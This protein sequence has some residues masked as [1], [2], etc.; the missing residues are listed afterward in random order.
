MHWNGFRSPNDWSTRSGSWNRAGN[1]FIPKWPNATHG[2]RWGDG[3]AYGRK[4]AA[5]EWCTSAATPSPAPVEASSDWGRAP[6]S[7]PTVSDAG[8]G[9]C[10]D[11]LLGVP[12]T[13]EDVHPR[14]GAA[15]VGTRGACGGRR[16]SMQQ[17][18]E[19]FDLASN[20]F[21]YGQN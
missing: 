16:R 10:V 1:A 8:G 21:A 5:R 3:I 9:G 15:E 6:Y 12:R 18:L 4:M 17:Q 14:G 11:E 19:F 20:R 2:D 7:E 13:V